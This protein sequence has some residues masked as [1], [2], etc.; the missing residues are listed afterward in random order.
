M[1]QHHLPSDNSAQEPHYLHCNPNAFHH[2]TSLCPTLCPLHSSCP[3]QQVSCRPTT[4]GLR[5]YEVQEPPMNLL[6]LYQARPHHPHLSEPPC[7]FSP[8]SNPLASN[9]LPTNS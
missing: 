2:P 6:Q 1:I 4:H 5:L 8:Q 9:T 3:Q 7:P